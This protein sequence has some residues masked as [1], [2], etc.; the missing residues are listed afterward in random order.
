MNAYF[1]LTMYINTEIS[2]DSSFHNKKSEIPQWNTDT[3]EKKDP[4]YIKITSKKVF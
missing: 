4:T 2:T 3:R 1:V